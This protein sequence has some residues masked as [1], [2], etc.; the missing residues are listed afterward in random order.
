[1]MGKKEFF[2]KTKKAKLILLTANQYSLPQG[3]SLSLLGS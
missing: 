3:K 2:S 1:M